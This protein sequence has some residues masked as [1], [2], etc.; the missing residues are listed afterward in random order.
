METGW[1][2]LQPLVLMLNQSTSGSIG[3]FVEA[4]NCIV[5]EGI[6]ERVH[7]LLERRRRLLL[8]FQL[9]RLEIGEIRPRGGVLLHLDWTRL[10]RV[11]WFMAHGTR[12]DQRN[13]LQA[14]TKEDS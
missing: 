11:R 6:S 4:D 8:H 5:V 2:H 3:E 13:T 12:R 1:H 9:E 10:E 14:K 7:Q